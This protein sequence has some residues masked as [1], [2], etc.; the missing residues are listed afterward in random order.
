MNHQ[1]KNSLAIVSS[2]LHL[3]ARDVG[4]AELTGHLQEASHRVAAIAR[5]HD[6]QLPVWTRMPRC[7][8]HRETVR[9]Q[10][11]NDAAAKKRFH[12]TR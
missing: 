1:V 4:N 12:R 10:M 9:E 5:A 11:P 6:Q 8:S 2:M 3:Q 7:G